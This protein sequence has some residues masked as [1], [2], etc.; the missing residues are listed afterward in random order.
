MGPYPEIIV[1]L[2]TMGVTF[3]FPFSIFILF[4]ST[5]PRSLTNDNKISGVFTVPVSGV[6]RV[7]YSLYSVVNGGDY[8]W[9][10]IYHNNAQQG[11]T[12]H[13]TWSNS[14]QVISTGAREV[15]LNARR[16]DSIY[17]RTTVML[18]EYVDISICFEFNT[19]FT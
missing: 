15:T 4:P 19:A 16:W 12:Q 3:L 9:A 8:N 5:S 13:S 1:S 7:S 6:W 17:L 11:E 14:G 10:W 2:L 18:G